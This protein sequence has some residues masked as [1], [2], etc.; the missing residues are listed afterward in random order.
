MATAALRP[1][2]MALITVAVPCTTS[3][4][5]NTPSRLVWQG[6]LV[7]FH[8]A[9]V[10]LVDTEAL[11]QVGLLA[12]GE[13]HRVGLDHVVGVA[14]RLDLRHAVLVEVEAVDVEELDAG[15]LARRRC[16]CASRYGPRRR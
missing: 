12:H 3:P 15:H 9:A 10:G 4:A 11:G 2:A 7:E 6:E 1:E 16:G 14:H 13:D 5:A 8:Q